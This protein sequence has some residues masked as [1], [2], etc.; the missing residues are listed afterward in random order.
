MFSMLVAVVLAAGCQSDSDC[1][2]ARVCEAGQCVAPAA[3]TVTP[4]P[5][6]SEPPSE[7]DASK[8]FR[9]NGQLCRDVVDQNGV[10][11]RE[12]VSETPPPRKKEWIRPPLTEEQRKAAMAPIGPPPIDVAFN[13]IVHGGFATFAQTARNATFG[14]VGASAST[15]LMHHRSGVGVGA[16][17]AANFSTLASGV[18]HL[19]V[20]GPV[21]RFGLTHHVSAG[22]LFSATFTPITATSVSATISPAVALEAAAEFGHLTL[23]LQPILRMD[24]S[25]VVFSL[26]AGVGFAL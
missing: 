3:A 18:A 21:V 7:N 20:G 25:G 10:T 17:L 8:V 24:A 12:C 4:P 2:D 6:V 11:Q 13:A 5:L 19:W 22:V 16:L 9:I 15:A 26:T 23:A 14:V 1:A